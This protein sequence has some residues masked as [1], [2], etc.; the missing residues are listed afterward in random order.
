[1]EAFCSLAMS[2]IF[3]NSPRSNSFLANAS[4]SCNLTSATDLPYISSVLS[5]CYNK[6]L[7]DSRVGGRWRD[8]IIV[9]RGERQRWVGK[10]QYRVAFECQ[11]HDG[12]TNKT[13]SG[14]RN[15]VLRNSTTCISIS[16]DN[17]C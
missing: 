1:M 12:F 4:L 2:I 17:L 5:V 11:I 8:E 13:A 10:R 3:S 9:R 6:T 15:D 16:L 14:A 7:G